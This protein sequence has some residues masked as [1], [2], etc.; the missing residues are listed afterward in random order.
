MAHPYP[1]ESPTPAIN[2]TFPV[3]SVKGKASGVSVA[4][5]RS[6]PVLDDSDCCRVAADRQI[7]WDGANAD[8][9]SRMEL[10]ATRKR[11]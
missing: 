3:R 9:V 2:A 11:V 7:D 8:E 6:G 4:A 1:V 10:K 5:A